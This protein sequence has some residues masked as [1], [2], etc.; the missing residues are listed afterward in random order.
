MIKVMRNVVFFFFF[1]IILARV[2]EYC[3]YLPIQGFTHTGEIS[4]IKLF[5]FILLTLSVFNCNLFDDSTP[6]PVSRV[7]V[8]SATVNLIVGSVSIVEVTVLPTDATNKTVIWSSNDTAI[9]TVDLNGIITGNSVGTA[10]ITVT[11]ADGGY[12][13]TVSVTV[14]AESVDVSSVSVG[15][16]TVNLVVGDTLPVEVT[17]LPTDASNPALTWS[18][19][20]EAIATVDL[21]GVITGDSVGTATI[22]VTTTD[23]GYTDTVAVIVTAESVSVTGV[24]VDESTVSLIVEGAATV[25]ATV[26]PTDATEKTVTWS[27]SNGQVAT[28]NQSGV[29]TAVG[30]GTATI[31]VTTTDGSHRTT[32]S[33]TV[34][35]APAVRS[36][37][38][39]ESTSSI[40]VGSS[41]QLTV[42]V[43]VVGGAS[44]TVSW[45]TSDATVATVSEGVVTGVSA[46]EAKIIATSTVDNSKADTVTVTVTAAL[47]VRSV[48]L[49]KA[50]SSVEV[51]SSEQLTVAVIVVGG[52]S[53]A[54]SWTTSDAS[55]A[56]VSEGLVTGVSVGETKI[57]AT[58]TVD[59]SKA[60]TVTVTVTAV[61]SVTSVTLNKATSSIEV[62]SSEQL[63]VT[64]IVVGG[65]SQT[66]RWSS[67]HELIATVSEGVVTGVSAGE[68]KIIAT[69]TVDDSKTDT[70]TVTVTA[71]AVNVTPSVTSVTLNKATSSIEVGSSEQLTVAVI[72]VG[73]ASQ[74]VSWTS[75]HELIATVSEGLVTGVSVGEAKIIATS[76]VDNSKADTVTVTV[77]AVPSV[78]SVTL[79]KATSSIEVG[80]SEQLTVTVIVVGGASQTVSWT[81]LHELIATVSEG[82]VTGVSAG[83]AKIIAISTVDNSKADTVTVT[84]T[85]ALAVR[86]VSLNKATSSIEV[87]SSEQLTVAV[88]VVGGASQTVRWSSSDELIATVSEGLVTGVLVGEAKIIVTSTVDDSKADTVTVTVT[89]IPISVTGVTLD[90][91]VV[92]VGENGTERVW[93]TVTPSDATD[94][95]VSWTTSNANI[96]TVDTNGVITGVSIGT[97]TITVTTTDQGET[98]TVV[99]TVLKDISTG[100]ADSMGTG[101]SITYTVAFFA[102]DI[103]IADQIA[104]I[105]DGDKTTNA[106]AEV[107]F[108]V[109]ISPNQ[110]G[111]TITHHFSKTYQKGVYRYYSHFS[112]EI[113]GSTVT[114]MND[115]IVVEVIPIS[116][117]SG[118][119]ATVTPNPST[120][121]N[122]VVTTFE[123]DDLG[124]YEIEILGLEAIAPV[125]GVYSVILT[126]PAS[127]GDNFEIGDTLQLSAVAS[128]ASGVAT[129]VT[130]S[131]SNSSVASVN[132]S[133]EVIGL[134]LGTA[135][136]TATSTADPSKTA[137]LEITVVVV[138]VTGVTLNKSVATV[139]ENGTER[140][141]AA[142]VPSN[143]SNKAVSWTTSNANIAT[144]DSNGIITGVSVG[145]ATITVT[146][147]D[148][149]ETA[150]V[151]VTVLENLS[152]GA[153]ISHTISR[154]V[155][156]PRHQSLESYLYNTIWQQEAAIS[157]GDKT[158]KSHDDVASQVH[159]AD[160]QR[161]ATIT[162]HLSKIYQKGV[163]T[164]YGTNRR[165]PIAAM[166]GSTVQFMNGNIVIETVTIWG[167][168]KDIT[169]TPDPLTAFNKVVTTVGGDDDVS[170]YE[171]EILGLEAITPVGGIYLIKLIP[172]TSYVAKNYLAQGEV[173]QF[174]AAVSA[175]SG[176][177]TT[178]SW[179]TSDA[180][181]ATVNSSGE[182]TGISEGTA[183]ITATSTAD[184]SKTAELEITVIAVS[185]TGVTLEDSLTVSE[186]ATATAVATVVPSDATDKSVSWTTGDANIAT[187]DLN[188]VITGVLAGTANIIVTTTDG[189]FKDTVVVTVEAFGVISVSLD[190]TT[191]NIGIGF[192]DQLTATVQVEGGAGETV[193]WTTSDAVVVTVNSTGEITALTLGTATITATSTVDPT[194]TATAIITVLKNISTGIADSMGTGDSIS[195]TPSGAFGSLFNTNYETAAQQ[196]RAVSDGDK[197]TKASSSKPYQVFLNAKYGT[198]THHFSKASN[199]GVY[200]FYGSDAHN[201][202]YRTNGITVSF[203]FNDQVVE[204]VTI[205]NATKDITVTPN[206]S[207]IFNKVV[208]TFP[209]LST[210]FYE[211]EIFGDELI[212]LEDI[213]TGIADSVGTGDSITH[214]I[215]AF[216]LAS[217]TDYSTEAQQIAAISDG[218]KTTDASASK[219]YQVTIGNQNGATITHHFSKTYHKG[220]YTFYGHNQYYSTV[221]RS[222]VTFMNDTTVV[223]IDTIRNATQNTIVIPSPSTV[224]NKVVTTFK[225]GN[226]AFYEIEI[227]GVEVTE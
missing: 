34:A 15:S 2:I 22:T 218:D 68:A 220:F 125:G 168:T 159:I 141:W 142:V 182:V 200:I 198:I 7:F 122:K 138:S 129:T 53:Q 88:I 225:V 172:D 148:Q 165:A 105:S 66:V 107:D 162:H 149:G 50:T 87:G 37:S 76:T 63:T 104:A 157:D 192:S 29:I 116:G 64:V 40:E 81:S 136:I 51:G 135:T 26:L 211:I 17:V 215:T 176:T 203:M 179:T 57:I 120:A 201:A 109:Y 174:S 160:N 167:A 4:M 83:E 166:N 99:V 123:T 113:N 221:N 177:A 58:S 73:G 69:S 111:R 60:D 49:N 206:P 14:T 42:T 197:T 112:H 144:V 119:S 223:Q 90:K 199:K 35:P 175:T 24:S 92:T 185:V 195:Y 156:I 163:Y 115:S 208:T 187:V 32:V 62:G 193:T 20:N 137:E 212:G 226:L 21:N 80:S 12:T 77:T 181:I 196:V 219:A 101:D 227:F 72:V 59:N 6:I 67:L 191:S 118:S 150:T 43:I 124:F 25:V 121:F 210:H 178:V 132:S 128:A 140:V 79:N 65:A 173:L 18:S 184:I 170:F 207:T 102:V 202:I 214:T 82:V 114:F 194:K 27:T 126:A 10:T 56:T 161:G 36:V 106:N 96:A 155:I 28:V 55:V 146:T 11:T 147:T 47:A 33:V 13:D 16:D 134:R 93:A 164:Y 189:N 108:Q 30:V 152:I 153:T 190:K 39:S 52:A 38:L 41:E 139:G 213:S 154:F 98:A 85:A 75:L 143:A 31:T 71:A 61:P 74:T 204:T 145:T 89:A 86:S 45:T 158:T 44:Q 186:N 23:G 54:V 46:G 84:V 110:R 48:S 169:V 133:G 19:S 216:F 131:S 94:K 103:S 3:Y 183:I 100:I 127:Y 91:S 117:A 1:L 97:A 217:N 95:L 222:T 9:A 188:G 130:W 151:V 180:G 70:V 224:F 171:I 205:T 209:K 78:T 5:T 8:G